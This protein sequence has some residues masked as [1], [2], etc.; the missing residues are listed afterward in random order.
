MLRA[1]LSMVP[2]LALGVAALLAACASTSDD[3]TANMSP[4]K[5]YSEA[6]DEMSSGAYDKAV[7]LF[8]KLEGRAAGTPLA[9]QAQLEKAYA[10]YKAND[11]A[12]ALATL[13][14]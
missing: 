3:K 7:P 9:Q 13:D 11:Q 2:A 10:Q 8:E 6:K 1:K 5:I 4:N 14:R 12:Q